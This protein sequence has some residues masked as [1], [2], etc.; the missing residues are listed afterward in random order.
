M[1]SEEATNI[2]AMVDEVLKSAKQFG[3]QAE[4]F[5][6]AGESLYEQVKLAKE[7]NDSL[8]KVAKETDKLITET[9]SII[10]EDFSGPIET[11]I[12]RVADSLA[13]SRKHIDNVNGQYQR[14]L[15]E[16]STNNDLPIIQR[17]LQTIDE[18]LGQIQDAIQNQIQIVND[19]FDHIHEEALSIE[20]G[21]RTI[22]KGI[23]TLLTT[24]N[25]NAAKAVHADVFHHETETTKAKLTDLETN[26][27]D[28]ERTNKQRKQF[29]FAELGLLIVVILLLVYISFIK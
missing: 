16:L 21:I 26:L 13:E 6:N 3:I 23:D 28:I 5:K 11:E 8:A 18:T 14:A 25:E 10:H 27:N 7:A 1:K 24:E 22:Q 9:R 17:Q 29:H 15:E 20:T 4:Q 12:Q 19:E 2:K